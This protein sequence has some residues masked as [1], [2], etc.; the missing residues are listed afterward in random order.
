MPTITIKNI[1]DNVYDRLKE[2]AK[3]NHRSLN[4][5]V[6]V[7]MERAA[8]LYRTDADVERILAGARATREMTSGYVLT[9]ED[10]ESAINEGRP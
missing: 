1:P 2:Q 5:E 7:L 4:S 8:T 10:I 3:T 9:P 6:I